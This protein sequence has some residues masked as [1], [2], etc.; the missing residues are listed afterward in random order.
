MDL[1]VAEMMAKTGHDPGEPYRELTKEL[2]KPVYERI[3]AAA[4]T[5]QKTI[6]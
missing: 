1:L 3:D 6:L 5:A 2:G 4:T